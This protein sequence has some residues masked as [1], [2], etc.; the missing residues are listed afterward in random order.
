[1][2][3]IWA[4]G[5]TGGLLLVQLLVLDVAGLK[6]RHRPGAPVEPDHG[7]FLFRASR[8]HANTNESIA[9]FILLGL[10]GVLS[11]AP[12]GWLNTLSWVYILARIAHMLCYYANVQLLRSLSFGVGLAAL[13]GMLVVGVLAWS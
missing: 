6:A 9:A 7:N 11:A 4:M 1:M 12:A 10:F 2:P 8:A 5:A 3:T 13:F